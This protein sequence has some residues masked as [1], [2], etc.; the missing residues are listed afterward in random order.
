MRYIKVFCYA[1]WLVLCFSV[2]VNGQEETSLSSRIM[3]ALKTMEP[4]WKPIATIENLIPLV[5][6]QRRILTAVWAS[7][8]SR[9]EDVN[10]SVYRVENHAE[11]AAWLA[12]VRDKRAAA[13]WQVNTYKIGD[14]GYLS[15]YE[16]GER[17]EIEF[18]RGNV[19]AKI[20]G[21]YLPRVK[22]FAKCVFDQIP[23]N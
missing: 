3:E 22:D 4:G 1:F 12:P 8:R 10:V 2:S 18:R 7:P 11:A 13:G 15:K 5:P 6:S 16:D 14:E 19:V 20:A 23:S 21:N 9:S 17:F